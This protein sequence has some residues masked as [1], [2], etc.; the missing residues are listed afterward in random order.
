MAAEAEP[1]APGSQ[2]AAPAHGKDIAVQHEPL[3]QE[4][5]RET[6]LDVARLELQK[7]GNMWN[8]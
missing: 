3:T 5:V 6:I 1:D 7:H 8:Y 4:N 2:E